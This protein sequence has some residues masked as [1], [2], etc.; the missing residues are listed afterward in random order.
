M[1]KEHHQPEVV[2]R[3]LLEAAPVIALKTGIMNWVVPLM[4]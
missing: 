1:T 3:A 4:I 2:E